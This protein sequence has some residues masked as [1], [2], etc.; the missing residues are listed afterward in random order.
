MRPNELETC[1]CICGRAIYFDPAYGG[2]WSHLYPP[3]RDEEPHTP[4]PAEQPGS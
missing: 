3:L 1:G 2:Y 4:Q